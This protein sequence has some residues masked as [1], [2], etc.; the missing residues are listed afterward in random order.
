[1][2]CRSLF[3]PSSAM[4]FVSWLEATWTED[5][6]AVLKTITYLGMC[7]SVCTHV[8]TLPYLSL[9]E[10]MRPVCL[11]STAGHNCVLRRRSTLLRHVRSG[12]AGRSS[13]INWRLN[14]NT[15]LSCRD[16]RLLW[17]WTV[18][19][20]CSRCLSVCIWLPDSVTAPWAHRRSYR[21][22]YRSIFIGHWCGFSN[23]SIG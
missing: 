5:T 6:W 12:H 9:R 19:W 16:L 21:D 4:P 8:E 15:L 1:M 23:H 10:T 11:C 22:T 20:R 13:T 14:S 7:V 2:P 3:S 17:D 18:N